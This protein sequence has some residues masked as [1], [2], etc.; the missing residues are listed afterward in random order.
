M[1]TIIFQSAKLGN[2]PQ[3]LAEFEWA[4]NLFDRDFYVGR[5]FGV[6]GGSLVALA[7]ALTLSAKEDSTRWGNASSAMID[8][9]TFLCQSNSHYIR[10]FCKNPL[11]GI[12]NLNPLR[13]WL[14]S[15]LNYYTAPNPTINSLDGLPKPDKLRFSHLPVQLYLCVID[16]DGTFTPFGPP[17]PELSFQYHTIRVGPP[18]DAPILDTLIASLSTL[19]STEPN[20]INGEWF[21][22]CRPAIVDAGAIVFDM[23]TTKPAPIL[24]TH[25]YAPIRPWK[26]NWITSSFVMHSQNERNQTLLASY[27]L[28]LQSRHK[29]LLETVEKLRKEL[30]QTP[31]KSILHDSSPQTNNLPIIGHI[32]LPYIGSTEASTNMRQSVRN[33]VELMIQFQSLLQGQFDNFPFDRPANVIYGAGGFSGI[34]AG[35]VTTRLVDTCFLK[36]GGEIQQVYGISAG[37]LNGFF[38]AVQLAAV[39]F[40]DLYKSAASNALSDLEQFIAHIHPK[41]VARVNLNPVRFWQGWANLD[42]LEEF[43]LDRLSTYTGSHYPAQITF[44]DIALPMTVTAA[45]HD[46]YTE[47][48]GMTTPDRRM[49]FGDREC[50]ILAAPV[51]RAIIAGWSMN[52][53]IIP[54]RYGEQTYTDG[55]GSFYDIGLFAALMDPQLTNLLNIHLD[56]PEGHS[57]NLP[58]RP[59]LMRILLDTHNYNFPE[60]RR[61]MRLLTDLLYKHFQLRSQLS[62]WL[63]QLPPELQVKYPLFPDFRRDWHVKNNYEEI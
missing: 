60:E 34:L 3:I 7:L 62:E 38:H 4:Q 11:Y 54:A 41:K 9:S 46:G 8:F 53:Y 16:R 5:I 45:R 28:D 22:D 43:F 31:Q 21:R 51:V 50:Q 20:L 58:P 44:D 27:Y 15:R 47:Y 59:N 23:Q 17:D 12:Y 30:D 55:G 35:L 25:P 37:V 56:E 1:N 40:P 36:E 61:R 18:R 14:F 33:K 52:T 2:I 49:Y 29:S 39:R 42:P 6:S 19:L 32:D 24:R 57:Y 48:F 26:L 10:S 63:A 13:R